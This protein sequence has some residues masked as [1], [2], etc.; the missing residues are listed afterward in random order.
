MSQRGSRIAAYASRTKDADYQSKLPALGTYRQY[1][2]GK[3]VQKAQ[4]ELRSRVA[5]WIQMEQRK[6]QSDKN[7]SN[8]RRG[9]YFTQ[10]VLGN[11]SK[12]Q[13]GN[14][15]VCPPPAFPTSGRY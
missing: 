14:L 4:L 13:F 6:L 7:Q 11:K 3:S 1:Y 10:N 5:S 8:K 12:Q 9:Q 15:T 2:T